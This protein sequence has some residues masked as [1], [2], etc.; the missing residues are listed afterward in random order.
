MGALVE[1]PRDR[2]S[3]I[4]WFKK[5]GPRPGFM[6]RWA[7]CAKEVLRTR[8]TVPPP[9]DYT[10]ALT[11]DQYAIGFYMRRDVLGRVR[12]GHP[13]G[14]DL[15]RTFLAEHEMELGKP[16]FNGLW[17]KWDLVVHRLGDK[18]HL[19]EPKTEKR[20]TRV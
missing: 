12:W 7:E 17:A 15:I 2:D 20:E 5:E 9:T 14:R 18:V 19:L 10:Q 11:D 4:E 6:P 13:A 8:P 16:E 3:M 1:D